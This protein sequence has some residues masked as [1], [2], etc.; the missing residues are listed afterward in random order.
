MFGDPI[1]AVRAGFQCPYCER[2]PQGV[3]RGAWESRSARKADLFDYVVEGGFSVVQK[4]R[5]PPQGNEHVIIQWSVG[6]PPLEVLFQGSLSG[7]V[8]GDKTAF[9]ELRTANDQTVRGD[10][11]KTE[12]DCFRHAKPRTGQQGKE[13]TVSTPTKGIAFTQLRCGLEDALDV[14][15]GENVGNGRGR[16][17]LPKT[18][19]GISWCWSSARM[20]RANR[21]TW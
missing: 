9:A 17:S 8:K 1:P 2:V 14:V 3:N 4:Y 16:F 11:L 12:M 10:V 6:T 5:A 13:R 15:P 19:G 20:Y 21:M 18:A 7:L